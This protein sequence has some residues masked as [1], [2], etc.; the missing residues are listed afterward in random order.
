MSH[1]G[2][3]IITAVLL[4]GSMSIGWAMQDPNHEQD[5]EMKQSKQRNL[6]L[7]I[8]AGLL[9]TGLINVALPTREQPY[10]VSVNPV[11]D[12]HPDT[13]KALIAAGL[14]VVVQDA[15]AM[16]KLY[17]VIVHKDIVEELLD[18]SNIVVQVADQ[19]E[20]GQGQKQE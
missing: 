18:V 20:Q 7:D 16:K 15:A 3:K 8:L 4:S 10:P 13:V 6:N 9:A 12:K 2:K 1:L 14:D 19:Q 11:I 17:P 5:A